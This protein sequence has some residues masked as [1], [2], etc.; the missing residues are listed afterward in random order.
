MRKA[1][2][3]RIE[4]SVIIDAIRAHDAGE[5]Q[6]GIPS[7]ANHMARLA[8]AYGLSNG[9][10]VAPEAVHTGR[11]YTI[12]ATYLKIGKVTFHFNAGCTEVVSATVGA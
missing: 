7:S 1:P 12:W 2:P 6:P 4:Q 3:V 8:V 5:A 10:K 9:P 11:G